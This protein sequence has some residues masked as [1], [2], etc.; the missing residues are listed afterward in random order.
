MPNKNHLGTDKLRKGRVSIPLA[1]YFITLSTHPRKSGLE[2]REPA[3]KII[4]ILRK[5]HLAEDFTL[6]CGTVMPDHIHLLFTLGTRIELAQVIGKFK[7]W[8]R[9]ALESACLA[10]QPNF[11][12]HRI[13]QDAYL[14][15]FARYI[16]LNPYRKN[17][18]PI[19]Q[20]WENWI[21]STQFKPEFL[22]VL[23][24][25]KYP[26]KEWLNINEESIEAMITSDC[27]N[28]N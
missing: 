17:L 28:Q 24:H 1:R 5:Q 26:Q 7:R 22:S 21:C 8:T 11:Y 13:R 10:W 18:I 12:D 19:D 27:S 3:C 2:N 25:G 14:E 20:V 16:F 15:P 4:D 23:N 6:H 9:P